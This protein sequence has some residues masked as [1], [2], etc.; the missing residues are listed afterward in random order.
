[1]CQSPTKLTQETQRLEAKYSRA[2][3]MDEMAFELHISRRTLYR[4]M[5]ESNVPEYLENA[6]GKFIFPISS[7]AEY[8]TSNLIKTN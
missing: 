5:D 4:R 8:L 3:S 6:T 7:V 1:M 2:L